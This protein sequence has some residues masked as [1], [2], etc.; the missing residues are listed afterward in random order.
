MENHRGSILYYPMVLTIG[1]TPWSL[2]AVAGLWAGGWSCLKTAPTR[3]LASFPVLWKKNADGAGRGGAAGYRLLV[4][5]IAV[6]L[7]CF[8][9]A[10]TKL[11]NYVLPTSVPLALLA[12]QDSPT[13]GVRPH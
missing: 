6:F 2:L 13:M 3:G 5:W 12:A 8:T 9:I 1:L 10:A 7:A 4:L 11:P